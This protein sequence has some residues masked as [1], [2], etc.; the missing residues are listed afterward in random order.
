MRSVRG[1]AITATVQVARVVLMLVSQVLLA[2][3]L[4]PGDFGMVAMV[5]PVMG[6]V[7]VIADLGIGQA[8]VSTPTL[9]LRQINAFFWLNLAL[10]GAL[11][12]LAAA[13]APFVAWFYGEPR[14]VPVVLACAGL[15][16]VSG[17]ALVQAALINRRM[18][19]GSIAVIDVGALVMSVLAGIAAAM[20]GWGYWALI[21]SQAAYGITSTAATMILAP[22]R[23]SWPNRDGSA[24]AL[25]RYGGAITASNVVNYVNVSVDNVIIGAGLGRIPLGF[26]DRAWKLA[27]QPIN[28]IQAPFGRVA[29]PALSRLTDDPGTYRNA[30]LR[31]LQILLAFSTPTMICAAVVAEP[32]VTLALGERWQPIVPLFAL[33]CLS[34]VLTPVNGASFWLLVTQSRV[35]EQFRLSVA[36]SAINI[37][38]YAVGVRFGV[39]GLVALSAASVFLLQTP[40][41]LGRATSRGPVRG[42][43]VLPLLLANGA[44][45]VATGGCLLLL[46]LALDGIALLVIAPF[47]AMF[48][49]LAVLLAL[50]VTRGHM[51]SAWRLATALLRRGQPEQPAISD[52]L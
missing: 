4:L 3:L 8:V 2:R 19:Y 33:L 49:N 25:L 37:V 44:A 34:G 7:Q 40:L 29:I 51:L 20:A 16:V 14:L 46:R 52:A 42:R 50:P 32:L 11:A 41:L 10:S 31:M 5:A 9:R 28:Q 23:P 45:G 47:V 39:V 21:V 26:Y 12:L 1:G 35:G 27:V 24:F 18:M 22:W 36:T 48:V 6:F 30:F 17:A 15:I 38:A 43:D 13:S